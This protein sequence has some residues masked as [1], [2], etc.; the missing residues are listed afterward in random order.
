MGHVHHQWLEDASDD[1]QRDY[2][3]ILNKARQV[4]RTQEA[5]HENEQVWETF[6]TNWLPPQYEV[7]TR[8]Y[9]VGTADE[10]PKPFETDLIVFHPGYPLKLRERTHVMAAGVA[11]A[12]STKL[13]LKPDGVKEAAASS[14]S[15]HQALIPR[16]GHL[17]W[18]VWKP[19]I[20]GVLAASHA[21]KSPNSMPADNL[22]KLI[23]EADYNYAQHPAE[24]L[25]LVCVADLGT[26][27]KQ[28]V[29]THFPPEE[30][31]HTFH[32]HLVGK[33]NKPVVEFLA[34]LYELLSW[35]N[36]DMEGMARDFLVTMNDF[37]ARFH[38]RAWKPVRILS[39]KTHFRMTG[40]RDIKGPF[41]ATTNELD[42]E[43]QGFL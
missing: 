28:L 33:T 30:V 34:V 24:S 17:R 37:Q 5:G 3:R 10:Q 2:D 4:G 12:F 1:I 29:Y 18:E 9:I 11:A 42:S 38:K 31:M 13:T 21:W 15:L 40:R 19:Y 27:M 41:Q 22:T 25:D 35:R 43:W 26:W 16:H 6:L 20:Y 36:S 32:A 23:V 39:P 7:A 8:K 14:A